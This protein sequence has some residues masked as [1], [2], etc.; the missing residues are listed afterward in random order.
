MKVIQTGEAPA[1]VGPY[2][3]AVES[4]GIIFVSGQVG[5]DPKTGKNVE[6]GIEKETEQALKNIQVILKKAGLTLENVAKVTVYLKDITDFQSM[7]GVYS[8]VFSQHKPARA[9]V[10]ANMVK[11]FRVE[12][13]CIATRDESAD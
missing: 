2:S 7:N 6:G 5:I 10:E 3:Q 13:D 9:C 12:I 8:Q 4:Q 11:D 1:P